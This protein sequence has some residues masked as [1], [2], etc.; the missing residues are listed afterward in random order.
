MVSK[1]SWC[2]WLACLFAGPGRPH[3]C[4]DCLDAAKSLPQPGNS[5]CN[6]ERMA[7][8]GGVAS[9]ISL[10]TVEIRRADTGL[11]SES[12]RAFSYLLV[13]QRDVFEWG[14]QMAGRHKGICNGARRSTARRVQPGLDAPRI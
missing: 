7:N 14:R 4:C 2:L 10:T 8:S 12:G 13:L 5:L 11:L 6:E 9:A 3:G 1:T